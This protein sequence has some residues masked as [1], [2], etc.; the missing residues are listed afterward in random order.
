MKLFYTGNSPYARRARMA[1]RLS[2]LEVEEVDVAPLAVENH[3]LMQKGPGGKVPGLETDDGTYLC[4]TLVITGY[5][6]GL[7][8]GRM[9]PDDPQAATAALALEGVGSL[10]LESLFL[11][12]AENRRDASEQSPGVLAKEALRTGRCY[13]ELEKLL[14]NQPADLNLGT[15]A[16]ITALGYADWRQPGDDWRQGR[17][18]LAAWFDAM[19]KHE[20]V[21][22]TH[23]EF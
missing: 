15:I 21:A 1:A 12:S 9:M 22:D 10:L 5:L 17:G 13:D 2:G 14:G 19:M 16:A 4:E 3:V 18:G 6:N 23:P 20:M 8:G 7:C 11:R